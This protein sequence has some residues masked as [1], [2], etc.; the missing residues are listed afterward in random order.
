MKNNWE[1]DDDYEQSIDDL[2]VKDSALG[3]PHKHQ[4]E[5][6]SIDDEVEEDMRKYPKLGF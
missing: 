6:K 3:K 4:D 1:E 5:E 2:I